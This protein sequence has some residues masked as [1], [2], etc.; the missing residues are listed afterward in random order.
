MT[1]INIPIKDIYTANQQDI[2]E[3]FKKMISRVKDYLMSD[4]VKDLLLKNDL[5]GGVRYIAYQGSYKEK[6]TNDYFR[7]IP[8]SDVDMLVV[9]GQYHQSTDS[10]LHNPENNKDIND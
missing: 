5:D 7:I 6:T 8:K 9:I 1:K 2:P 3:R 10:I 4:D